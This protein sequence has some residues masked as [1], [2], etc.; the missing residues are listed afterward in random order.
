MVNG[1]TKRK[2]IPLQ[3][4]TTRSRLAN[5]SFAVSVDIQICSYAG[6]A[7]ILKKPKSEHAREG[8]EENATHQL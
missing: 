6:P 3:F 2:I 4:L 8:E 5:I 1:V 7:G